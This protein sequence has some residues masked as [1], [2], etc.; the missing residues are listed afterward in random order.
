L[1]I[2]SQKA[3]TSAQEVD[4]N[5]IEFK[6][7]GKKIYLFQAGDGNSRGNRYL[8]PVENPRDLEILGHKAILRAKKW[9][10]ANERDDE[11]E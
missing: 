6:R 8:G 4:M 1:G 3:K 10:A 11:D 2:D 9:E 7:I 5:L